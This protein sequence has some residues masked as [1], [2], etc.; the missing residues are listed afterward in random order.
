MRRREAKGRV[1]SLGLCGMSSDTEGVQFHISTAL[2]GSAVSCA[3]ILTGV[4]DLPRP[5]TQE[6]QANFTQNKGR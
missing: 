2:Q 3:E 6:L 5:C 4:L 1:L